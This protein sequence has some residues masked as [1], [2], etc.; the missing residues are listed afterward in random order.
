MEKHLLILTIIIIFFNSLMVVSQEQP[1]IDNIIAERPGVTNP[2]QTVD[3]KK[4]QIESGFYYESDKI[5]NTDIKTD[6]YLYPTTLLRYGLL[7][8]FELRLQ[9]DIAGISTST[10]GSN[11]ISASGLNPFI[12]GGKIYVCEQKKLRPET[13]FVFG[14]T[15]PFTGK[16]EFRPKYITPAMAFYCLN[17]INNKWNIGYN[18]GMQWNGNDANPVYNLSICPG[19]NFSGKVSGFAEIYSSYLSGEIPDYRCDAG[20]TYTPIPNLQLDVY[21]G[22][23]ISGPTN[24]YFISAGI[25]FRTPKL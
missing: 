24:N 13:G 8:N 12:I 20:L 14:L 9:V 18:I 11:R 16:Q 21:G 19:Y 10:T 17:T 2:P 22:P 25:S 4:L 6:N 5:K 3:L 15:L 1:D 7:K 23:G